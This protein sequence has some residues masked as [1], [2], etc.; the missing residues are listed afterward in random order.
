VDTASD[1]VP[2]FVNSSSTDGVVFRCKPYASAYFKR[3]G[4]TSGRW[5]DPMPLGF[6]KHHW[7]TISKMSAGAL[8]LLPVSAKCADASHFFDEL[9]TG[10][11]VA[12][13]GREL[14]IRSSAET[15]SIIDNQL[16]RGLDF[17]SVDWV[18]Q[19]GFTARFQR[20]LQWSILVCM[21]K[22]PGAACDQSIQRHLASFDVTLTFCLSAA[23][24]TLA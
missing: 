22:W 4:W 12:N 21:E 23:L 9:G 18:V 24:F 11:P 3:W 5:T 13:L 14:I 7:K 8:F 10:S 20:F 2:L 15:T 19:L 1:G 6:Q 16:G 17:L